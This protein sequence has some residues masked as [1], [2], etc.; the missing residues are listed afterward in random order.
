MVLSL[1]VVAQVGVRRCAKSRGGRQDWGSA[2]RRSCVTGGP[3]PAGAV[4]WE[5]NYRGDLPL[6]TQARA[7]PVAVHDGWSLFCQGWAALAAVL[8][9][10]DGD[11]GDRFEL[12]A[13]SLRPH[14]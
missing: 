14:A 10:D 8:E 4:V 3:V 1:V 6:L 11:L 12:A 5:L 7:Q 2:G 9:L 13:R